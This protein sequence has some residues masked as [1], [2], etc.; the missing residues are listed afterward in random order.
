[1]RRVL[2]SVVALGLVLACNQDRMT[3]PST[4]QG[5]GTTASSLNGSVTLEVGH[6]DPSASAVI[7]T[8]ADWTLVRVDVSGET[9]WNWNVECQV[10]CFP[11]HSVGDQHI[12]TNP[13][14][15]YFSGWCQTAVGIF[16][17]NNFEMA[18]SGCAIGGETSPTS[19]SWYSLVKGTVEAVRQGAAQS[20]C[21][22]QGGPYPGPLCFYY[23]GSADVTLTWVP[24][25]LD[26]TASTM[27]VPTPGTSVTF[28]ATVSPQV[29]G[30]RPVP[31]KILGWEWT[32][33][34]GSSVNPNCGTAQQCVY[35]PTTSGTMT[36]SALANQYNQIAMVSVSIA[37]TS[38]AGGQVRAGRAVRIS[39]E[40][41]SDTTG[42]SRSGWSGDVRDVV[43]RCLPDPVVRGQQVT[44]TFRRPGAFSVPAINLTEVG[45]TRSRIGL[46]ST[47]LPDGVQLQ[48]TALF[49]SRLDAITMLDTVNAQNHQT[50][51]SG[52]AW[53]EFR[54]LDRAEFDDVS[55]P[56]PVARTDT[57]T[58]DVLYPVTFGTYKRPQI[59][60]GTPSG[61]GN[62]QVD[63]IE[64]GPNQGFTYLPEPVSLV[65]SVIL[66][67]SF[68]GT[69]VFY[70]AQDGMLGD[71]THDVNN[72]SYCTHAM[73]PAILPWVRRHEGITGATAPDSHWGIDQE[74]F[75]ALQ[76]GRRFD[77]WTRS[78]TIPDVREDLDSV[79]LRVIRNTRPRQDELDAREGFVYQQNVVGCSF[80]IFDDNQLRIAARAR[81]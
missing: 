63:S 36:V 54:V 37:D 64:V 51:L 68:S 2:Q 60:F 75:T 4:V 44:C 74:Q 22:E 52:G 49:S 19:F 55:L 14:G 65:T 38:C 26:V 1:M 3:A 13:R 40:C 20:R 12:R 70:N 25:Y 81:R 69:G 16:Y 76:L 23:E 29:V 56:I 32:T 8:Y 53:V 41:E 21:P 58:T 80:I 10:G 6:D 15:F 57:A 5:P 66:S 77:R 39:R 61:L 11:P 45:G 71:S 59:G 46:T 62:V 48:G 43:G 73:F 24:A 7:G 78:Q 34:Y 18:P 42:G 79:L 31:L 30:G 17:L 28:S 9:K 50:F 67:E 47:P 33:I 35:A 72:R 27:S